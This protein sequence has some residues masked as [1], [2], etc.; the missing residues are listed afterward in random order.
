MPGRLELLFVL[1]AVAWGGGP[2]TASVALPLGGEAPLTADAALVLSG[3]VDYLRLERAIALYQAG[4]V[5]T[6]LLTGTGV[7]G[8]SA[9]TMREIALGRGVPDTAIVLEERSTTTRENLAFMAPIIRARGF[10]RVALVTSASHMER[11]RGVAESVLPEVEWVLVPVPD[12]G[13]ADRIRQVQLQESL[14]RI[15]YSLLGWMQ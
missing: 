2:A 4:Q 11:A 14:K 7:G 1:F 3:D 5:G 6:L 15:W 13:S 10:K 9:R 12:A 8:D